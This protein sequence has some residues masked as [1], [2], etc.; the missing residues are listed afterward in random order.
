MHDYVNGK[1][2]HCGDRCSTGL[3]ISGGCVLGIGSCTDPEIVIPTV[4]NGVKI[5]KIENFAF[6][7]ETGITSIIIPDTV[8]EI[9]SCAFYKCDNL[10][11]VDIPDSVT[12]IGQQ[13][14]AECASI[15]SIV[16]PRGLRSVQQMMFYGCKSLVSLTISSNVNSLGSDLFYSVKNLKSIYYD[17]S[18][19]DWEKISKDSSW[20]SMT[21]TFTVYCNDG[22]KTYT[23]VL[24]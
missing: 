3:Q 2:T 20:K 11:N 23:G 16:L 4:H 19:S 12:K 5:T 15:A 6:A 22:Y 7:Y 1:C 21:S 10:K 14:F 9:G 8:T 18:L 17:G 24:K 13:A